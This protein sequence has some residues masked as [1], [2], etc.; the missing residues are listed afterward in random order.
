MKKTKE[1][2]IAFAEVY[3]IL[4]L[5]TEEE[6]KRIPADFLEM[7]NKNKAND[8]EYKLEKKELHKQKMTKETKII[9]SVIYRNYMCDEEE[10]KRL[11]LD[12]KIQ[13]EKEEQEKR[14]KYNPE[15]LFK[16]VEEEK[17]NR[18]AIV[19]EVKEST[20]L[21]LK[22]KWTEK[23]FGFVKKIISIFKK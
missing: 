23:L 12:D 8:Y 17:N 1:Y 7:I 15:N 18:E 6:L 11:E 3:E 10:R 21:V 19:K 5:F 16:K 13:L 2:S 20:D 22:Q 4:K 14:E 9:L